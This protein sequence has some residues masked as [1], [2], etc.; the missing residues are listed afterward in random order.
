MPFPDDEIAVLIAGDTRIMKMSEHEIARLR[1]ST[2]L[3]Y[4]FECMRLRYR[5]FK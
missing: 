5:S 1:I 2:L 3:N 4:P